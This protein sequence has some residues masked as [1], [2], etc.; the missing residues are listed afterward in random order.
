MSILTVDSA[1]PSSRRRVFYNDCFGEDGGNIPSFVL[2]PA[3][4]RRV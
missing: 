3:L 4:K 1:A 2:T